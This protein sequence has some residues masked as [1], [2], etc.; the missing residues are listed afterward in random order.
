M[1]FSRKIVR[2]KPWSRKDATGHVASV[3]EYPE[4][5]GRWKPE[6]ANNWKWVKLYT[7]KRAS[8]AM[9][10]DFKRDK[11]RRNAG[12]ITAEMDQAQRPVSEHKADY[13]AAIAM[14]NMDAEHQ[15]IAGWMLGKIIDGCDWKRLADIGANSLRKF[16]LSRRETGDSVEYQRKW[17]GRA[18]AF[19]HWLQRET[20]I[21]ID[22]LA[23]VKRPSSAKAKKPRA[24]RDLTDSEFAAL[25]T[26]APESRRW[27]YAWSCLTG[28]RRGEMLEL[29]E[30]DLRLNAPIP[31]IQLRLEWTKNDKNDVLALH[32]KLVSWLKSVITG[33]GDRR[34]FPS[35]PD[36]KTMAKD[37]Q[38]AGVAKFTDLPGQGISIGNGK[39]INIADSKGRRA[40]FHALRHTFASN[41]DRVSVSH[42]TRK[43]LLRHADSDITDG[44]SHAR[45]LEL[46]EAIN[47]LQIPTVQTDGAQV[48]ARTG[49]DDAKN[50]PRAGHGAGHRMRPT[51]HSVAET[52]SAPNL[53]E[54]KPDAEDAIVNPAVYVAF[55][56]L[57]LS[58]LK[59]RD[60]SA[61][62]EITRPSTQVD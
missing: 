45:L 6:G 30:D 35:V 13:L 15:R 18:K 58:L 56:D 4:W 48:I 31:F 16:I 49:T 10:E 61:K 39:Y 2:R 5:H 37:L 26:T 9:W 53:T 40:D 11:E 50:C 55:R 25:F 1:K 14:E 20:R 47:K 34:I 19:V 24:R 28:F 60:P 22:P 33:D 41:L 23:G 42:S 36:M 7:D 46:R 3:V 51:S 17:I 29:C 21:G 8:E 44:Y 32:P 12:V 54:H 38:R 59:L 57:A 52:S 43:S 62:V 27:I